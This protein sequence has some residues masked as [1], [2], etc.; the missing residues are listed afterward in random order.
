MPPSSASAP[1]FRD[2]LSEEDLV[3]LIGCVARGDRSAL[4]ALYEATSPQVFGLALRILR[5]R[6]SAEEVLLD[7]YVQI[8]QTATTYRKER[9]PPWAWMLLMTRSR[10]IDRL[11]SKASREMAHA[12]PIDT[13]R[14]SADS[15]PGPEENSETAKRRRL[16]SAALAKLTPEQRQA[17]DLAFFSGLSHSE[18]AAKLEKPLGTVKTLIRS[19]LLRLRDALGM[20]EVSA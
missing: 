10:A 17:V 19:G 8:W 5:D 4:A 9:G 15:A 7:V 13:L 6:A 20:N 11:R 12:Q 18:I 16:V 1:G 3:A 2:D 14:F